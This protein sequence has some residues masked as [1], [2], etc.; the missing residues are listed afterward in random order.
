M[1]WIETGDVDIHELVPASTVTT[2]LTFVHQNRGAN[3]SDIRSGTG[4]QFEYDD[5]RM[6][7]AHDS[8][9]ST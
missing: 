5:I 4:D 1:R 9:G 8:R 2:I 6:V 3:L 7:I